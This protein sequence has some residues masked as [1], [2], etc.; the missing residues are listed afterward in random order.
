MISVVI[1]SKTPANYNACSLAVRA[2]ESEAQITCVW[3]GPFIDR[4]EGARIGVKP[5]VFAR[6]V[7]NGITANP[8]AEGYIILNDDAILKTPGGFSVLQ[9][10]AKDHPEYG[11]IAATTNNV[12]NLNQRPQGIGLREDP[13]MVCF[14]CVYFPRTTI[15]TVGLLDER[16]VGYGMDDDDYCLRVRNAGLKIGI[17]DGCFVDHGSLKSSY[18]GDP[19][20]TADFRPNLELFKQKW[21]VD[22]WGNPA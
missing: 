17:H 13:R 11:I 7:N 21:G 3:D 14:V 19:G 5:F 15:E 2:N 1:P 4:P 6:N 20:K 8:D 16:F 10:A 9:Q 12:G 18:R 22:N